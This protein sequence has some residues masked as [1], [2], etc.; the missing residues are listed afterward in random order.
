M[1][2]AFLTYV[3]ENRMFFIC[4]P[5][6]F[7]KYIHVCFFA[8]GLLYLTISLIPDLPFITVKSKKISTVGVGSS[9][10]FKCQAL[11]KQMVCH[12]HKKCLRVM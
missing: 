9:I 3:L 4:S 11:S 1:R 10:F 8:R 12:C 5:I 6:A 2:I 7:F